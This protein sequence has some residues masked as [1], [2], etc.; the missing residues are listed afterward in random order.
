MIA[1]LALLAIGFGVGPPA[2]EPGGIGGV[3]FGTTKLRA[4]AELRARFGAPSAHGVNTGCGPRYTEVAWGD[5]V[6][7][8]RNDR[9]SG[10]RYL[11]AGWPLT[12][13][14][15][16]R[17]PSPSRPVSP[18][19]STSAGIA[20]G[21]TL[22]RLRSVYAMLRRVGADAWRAPNGLI[23]VDDARRDPPS[24][25]SLIVEIKIGTCGDF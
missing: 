25:S 21:S 5:L 19:L 11:R 10:Y 24:P 16:P 9:F 6:A 22:S 4:V 12:T 7:E 3:R 23:F 20:L 17:A 14:G 1:A 13:P 15:S 18:R 2:L 8:F